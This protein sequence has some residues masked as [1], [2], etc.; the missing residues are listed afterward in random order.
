MDE[1]DSRKA[2]R[3]RI[4]HVDDDQDFAELS[5]TF[6]E[7]ENSQFEVQ[8]ATNAS[9]G[10]VQLTERSF[11]CVVSDYDM[12]GQNGL[13]FLETV[14]EA[15][16]NLPFIIYTGKGSEEIASDAISAGVTDYLQKE[17]GTS[18]YTVLSNRISNAVEN[19]YAQKK[20]VDREQR[21]NLFFEESP[22]GAIEWDENFTFVRLNDTAEE[23]LGFSEHELVGESWERIVPESDIDSVDEVVSDLLENEGGYRRVN[24]NVRNDGQRIICE[25]HNRAVTDENGDVLTVFSK[26][27]DITE[28]R[29]Q[30]Q[31]LET[32][33]DNIPG[34]VYRCKNERGW[35]IEQ[36]R[37]NVEGMTGYSASKIVSTHKFYGEEIVH[38]ADR[39]DVWDNIQ[40]AVSADSPYELTY[41]ITNDGG[42]TKWV[43]ERGRVVNSTAEGTE[44]LEGLITDITERERIRRELNE[45]REFIDQ[46]LDALEE[47][48]Y[49]VDTDGE[50]ERWNRRVR[51]VP[52]Y[53]DDE[54]ADMQALDFFPAS[55]Q[56]PVSRAI[57]ETL[58][59]GSSVIETEILTK[60]GNRIPYELTGAR[61]TDVDGNVTGLVGIGRDIT[62]RLQRERE[63][64]EERNKYETVVEQS[65]DAI[66]IHQDG[67]FVYANP[68]CQELLGYDEDELIGKSFL[69][70]TPT[71]H[72][73]QIH[74]RYEQRLDTDASDPPSRYE[75][76]FI[77]KDGTIRL[78]EISAAPIEFEG[79][80]ADLVA[81]RDITERKNYEKQLKDTTAELEALNRVVRHDIRNDMS[82]ILG[83]AELL[84]DHVDEEGQ[85]YLRRILTSGT[86]I[87]ELTEIARDYVESLT[88][89]DELDVY[90]VSLRP[91]LESEIDI[92]RESHPEATFVIDTDIPD[93]EVRA[94]EMLG[95]V[96]RNIL[97]NAIQHNDEDEPLVTVSCEAR[98]DDVFVRIADNGPGIPDAQKSSIFG[99]GQKGLDSPG[100]GIG[101][102]LVESLITQYG[103]EV[104]VEDNDPKGAIF[105]ISI[106]AVT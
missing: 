91:I 1:R 34:I 90:P 79:E 21:L 22:L 72:R 84:N 46:A 32:L 93:S 61:L 51:E 30:T 102:Y 29:R 103:G 74:E 15:H 63:L 45:E 23:I 82:V 89:E 94:N 59:S 40:D 56:L 12:P 58:A 19:Y 104:W 60:S 88:S 69:E 97:N 105:N 71:E 76:E 64:R 87:V 41:R 9:E 14:R 92:R 31:Q 17:G 52:G 83:W 44:I 68:R 77:T 4:L 42:N 24:E 73:E 106:P 3:V 25:W 27:Q 36:V 81:V 13:E 50:L 11:D 39:D 10:F 33:I 53:T 65:H 66:A 7:R 95:S 101:L 35:P 99:K 6:L 80:P 28:R 100:T 67:V 38:P 16:P 78:A 18:Q 20:L 85:N 54:I 47:V 5:A 75:S 49:V 55:E 62:D 2:G 96:F 70:I 86:H 37:G 43:W 26:F 98:D 57:D 8:T 48:F